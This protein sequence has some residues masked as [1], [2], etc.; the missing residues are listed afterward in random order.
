ML[1]R[2]TAFFAAALI[3]GPAC[4]IVQPLDEVSKG[5]AGDSGNDAGRGGSSGQGGKSGR[6]GSGGDKG[7]S[8]AAGT[9]GGSSGSSGAGGTNAQGGTAGGGGA[10]GSSG[11][12]AGRGGGGQSGAGGSVS[13]NYV[14]VWTFDEDEQGWSINAASST[15]LRTSSTLV[16]DPSSGEPDDGSLILTVPFTDD[17]DDVSIAVEFPVGVDLRGKTFAARVRVDDGLGEPTSPGGV[18]IY[19]KTGDDYAWGDAGWAEIGQSSNYQIVTFDTDELVT[20]E[21][22]DASEVRE[23]GVHFYSG[24]R[25]GQSAPTVIHIDSIGWDAISRPGC[26]L[27]PLLLDDMETPDGNGWTCDTNGRGG[28][29]FAYDDGTDGVRDPDI[30]TLPATVL[31]T[32]RGKST[33]AVHLSG[34]G[35]TD[36]GGGMGIN[37]TPA[38]PSDVTFYDVS[39]YSGVKF[40]A[41]GQG[42][43]QFQVQQPSTRGADQEFPGECV[44]QFGAACEDHYSAEPIEL[45]SEWK[46]YELRWAELAQRGYG[47]PVPFDYRVFSVEFHFFGAQDFDFWIDDLRLVPRECNDGPEECNA[48]TLTASSCN[49]GTPVSDVDC[50]AGC[51]GYASAQCSESEACACLTPTDQSCVAAITNFCNCSVERGYTCD[52]ERLQSLYQ[53]CVRNYYMFETVLNCYGQTLSD[54]AAYQNEC[55]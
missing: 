16:H 20:D 15:A 37:L 50:N 23:I 49:L 43:M 48:N 21:G 36:W 29:W 41:R 19:A 53:A 38:S 10:G 34:S 8:G 30:N 55:G 6:A 40:W 35:F 5:E 32:P 39:K 25:N 46:E 18:Q 9:A 31:E 44:E 54:C 11:S 26:A 1:A 14:P 51:L 22:F 17:G 33:Q 27:D 47:M 4:L 13:F 42:Q 2:V 52:P 24:E 12:D 28:T 3:M 45:T 7:G